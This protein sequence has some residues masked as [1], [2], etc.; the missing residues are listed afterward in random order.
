MSLVSVWPIGRGW[1]TKPYQVHE[2][3][4][5]TQRQRCTRM[6]QES[7]RVQHETPPLGSLAG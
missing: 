6:F 7:E 5:P 3:L 4:L 2:D 1:S